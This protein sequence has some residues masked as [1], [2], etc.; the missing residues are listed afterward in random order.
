MTDLEATLTPAQ[1]GE[2][3]DRSPLFAGIGRPDALAAVAAAQ[4][5]ALPPDAILFTP[6]QV[7]VHLYLIVAGELI[8]S[9]DAAGRERIARFVPGDCL[10]GPAMSVHSIP[11]TFIL[12]KTR[13]Q[14]LV[15]D[16]EAT[17][18]LIGSLPKVAANLL[19]IQSLRPHMA[20][21]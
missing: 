8:G 7:S 10:G 21:G 14:L 13:S 3:L 20:V 5:V 17:W 18:N 15:F 2:V 19:R 6:G 9:R 1:L 4:T 12:A 11:L 16:R